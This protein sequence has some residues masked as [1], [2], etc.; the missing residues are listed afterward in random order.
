MTSEQEA[1]YRKAGYDRTVA[2]LF[3]NS[4]LGRINMKIDRSQ[5]IITRSSDDIV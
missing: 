5:S 3:L 2:K 1:E 4:L